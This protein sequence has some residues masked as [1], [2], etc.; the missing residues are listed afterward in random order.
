MFKYKVF[1]VLLCLSLSFLSCKKNASGGKGQ[2]SGIV[3]YDGKPVTP[4]TVYIKYGAT[5]SPG[6]DPI[7]YDSQV[8][9]DATGTFT[10]ASLYPGDY[11]LY[12][13]GKYTVPGLGYETVT[14]SA[15]AN[16]PHTKSSVNYDIATTK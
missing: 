1:G 8:S 5:T 15:Q 2:I 14:G 3:Y 12:A 9:V 13:I 6:T 4:C 11:F 10:F 16:I 7:Q